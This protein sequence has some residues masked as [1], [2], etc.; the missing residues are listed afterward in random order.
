MKILAKPWVLFIFVLLIAGVFRVAFMQYIEFK[1]D[2]ALNLFLA[3]RPLFHHPFPPASQASS[4]GILNFP[5][6]NYLLFPIAIFTLYPPTI[7]LVI[8]LLNVATV[9]AFFLLFSKYHDKL[10]GFLA[11]CFLAVSP[12][13]ILYSRKIWAQDFLL[14]LSF[15]FFLSIYKILE[16]KQKYWILLGISSMLLIQI[17]QIA[18]IIPLLVLLALYKRAFASWKFLLLGLGIGLIPAIPYFW[19]VL[20]HACITCQNTNLVNRLS[21][22]TFLSFFRP[23][24]L[25]SIGNFYKEFGDDYALFAVQ[26]PFFYNVGKLTYISYLLVPI[27]LIFFWLKSTHVRFFVLVT[28]AY[29]L[30]LFA[31]GIEPLMHYYILL[32]P[33]LSL[34]IGFL[35]SYLIRSKLFA[36]LGIGLLC[37]YLVSLVGFDTGFLL[38]LGL[39]GGL[40]GEYGS[41]YSNSEKSV[42]EKLSM[43]KNYPNYSELELI[44]FASPQYFHGYMPMGK[45]IFPYAELKKNEAQRE[46]QFIQTPTN[47]LLQTEIFAY[48]TQ[49]SNPSWQSVVALKEKSRVHNVFD[50]IYQQVVNDYVNINYKN[51][52]ETTDFLLLYPRHWIRKDIQR[53]VELTDKTVVIKIQKILDPK[54]IVPFN[55]DEAIQHVSIADK[56]V[57]MQTCF[58]NSLWCGDIYAPLLLRSADY[59]LTVYPVI[60]DTK[61]NEALQKYGTAIFTEVIQSIATLK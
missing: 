18:G 5:L 21:F 24:Q 22:H 4:A 37:I 31:A 14:P 46:K 39:K 13:A 28:V 3:S 55:G 7:S 8:A 52:Y 29:V 1:G 59:Q 51:L 17:H 25:L 42:Q 53:G 34:F 48:Y 58:S 41:G 11:S 30:L 38:F 33:L 40:G 57:N 2:E 36:F 20:P 19:Y 35:F 47:P 49:S 54:D 26:F 32:I 12:W 56:T 44:Y 9:G 45:M 6:L 27:G 23:L 16:G 43:F 15:P 50:F 61:T 10:T 60:V